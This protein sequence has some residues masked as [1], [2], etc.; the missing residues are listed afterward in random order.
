MR[1][2]KVE[3]AVQW[4][5]HDADIESGTVFCNLEPGFLRGQ[6]NLKSGDNG[7]GRLIHAVR[8]TRAALDLQ[9][10]RRCSPTG[11]LLAAG[12]DWQR[13]AGCSAINRVMIN[14]SVTGRIRIEVATS[15]VTADGDFSD[16][17]K[18]LLQALGSMA[19]ILNDPEPAVIVKAIS[20]A[21][22]PATRLVL[23]LP[24]TG[25]FPTPRLKFQD[26]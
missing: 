18:D 19:G 13:G 23:T 5:P 16:K 6:G 3:T 25:L 22:R 10:W 21:T 4:Q 12:A 14:H 1:L 2:A 17:Q 9:P 11:R 26:Q 8:V 15:G 20:G 24:R 7:Q